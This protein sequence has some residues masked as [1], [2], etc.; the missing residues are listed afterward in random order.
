MRLPNAAYATVADEKITKY[1]L[2]PGHQKGGSKAR[3]FIGYGFTTQSWQTL[4]DA[5]WN[6]GQQYDVVSTMLLT[7]PDRTHYVVEGT[8]DAPNG[9]KPNIRTVWCIPIGQQIPHLVTAL[10]A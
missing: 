4:R 2:D 10:P 7:Q 1:L 8:L 6:H 3:F 5:L 9:A